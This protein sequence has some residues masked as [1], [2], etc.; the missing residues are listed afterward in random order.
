MSYLVPQQPQTFNSNIRRFEPEFWDLNFNPEAVATIITTG[1][2][3]FRV[4]ALLRSTR[5]LIGVY[6]RSKDIWGHPLCSYKQNVD[7]R[8]CVLSFAMTYD[9]GPVINDS[10]RAL[11]I[12]VTDMSGKPHYLYLQ[13]FM[14][15]GSP[16]SRTGTFS[17]NFST[18]QGGLLANEPIP[19]DFIESMYIG[20][21]STSFDK[22]APL[23][24]ITET[25][26][27]VDVSAI[28]VTGANVNVP[29]NTGTLTAHALRIAD[30]YA[31]SYAQ[32]PARLVNQLVR[33]G[34]RNS[35]VMYVGFSQFASV[36]WNV[37]LARFQIDNAKPFVNVPTQ[38]WF[39]DYCTK[40][41]ANSMGMTV[42]VSYELLASWVPNA[43]IQKDWKGQNS[44]S[45]WSPPS[46]F[47]SPCS[48]TGMN[49]LRDVSVAFV[50][51]SFLAGATTRYQ[52]GEPWWWAGGYND[53]G[54]CLYDANT[55]ALYTTET[56]LPVP[57]PLLK[58]NFDD[59]SAPAQTAYVS[60]LRGK[61]GTSTLFLRNAVKAARPTVDCGVLFYTPTITNPITPLVKAY[62]FPQ[63]EWTSPA[64]DFIQV[65]DYEVVEYGNFFQ[66][67]LDLDVPIKDLGY[68]LSRCEYFS[69][70]NLLPATTFIW[71]KLDFAIWLAQ[72]VKSYPS[73]LVWARPQVFRDGWVFNQDQWA[74]YAAAQAAP[75]LPI[76]PSI[77][78]LGWSVKRSP[79]FRNNISKHVS[80]KEIRSPNAAHPV[81]E[82][83]LN[84]DV[85]FGGPTGAQTYQSMLSFYQ[86]MSGQSGKFVFTDP[87]FGAA[88]AQFI[89]T[90]DGFRT[91]WPLVRTVGGAYEEP[92]GWLVNITEVRIN[93]ILQSPATYV[94]W[95]NDKYPSVKFN[96][97]PANTAVVT[98]SYNYAFVCRFTNDSNT[99]EEFMNNWH[100]L[101]SLKFRTVKP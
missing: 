10:A 30:G 52:V 15:S 40:L 81:W 73:S 61:L 42:S 80:G 53:N 14:T 64:W 22:N 84:Y 28:S 24:P 48:T 6:W 58:T 88:I 91:T 41:A 36:S 101:K 66:M 2:N 71:Q 65:E 39:T 94:A 47:V 57:T 16:S 82:F 100:A 49:Y 7:W 20:F 13:N 63:T 45:G 37:G 55:T 46:S 70:F 8:N 92:I 56:S 9:A 3:S 11:V 50:N 93:G 76:F 31:D 75:T 67:R 19:W 34:Y 60:W 43:W 89:A 78:T 83:E 51:L 5:C 27:Q 90:G 85:L 18:A 44:E 87:E 69:G 98:A 12:T 96:T 99:F 95:Y 4:R 86:S 72:N 97:A 29:I 23:A 62:S 32:T 79:R 77:A 54:P 26:L 59:F 33:L 17:I 1:A 68:A 35:V 38:Q 25:A 21:T 74:S